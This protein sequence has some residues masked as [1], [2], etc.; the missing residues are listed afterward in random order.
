MEQ[1][2]RDVKLALGALGVVYG[3]LGTSPLYALK[4][5]LDWGGGATPQAALGM[6]S[7]I[8]WTLVLVISVKYVALVMRADSEGE[9]GI[10]VL[11]SQLGLK[12]RSRPLIVAFGILGAAL[13]YGDGAITPAISVLSALE[14]LKEPFPA[15]QP[16]ILPMT[17]AILGGLFIL[18]RRG[19]ATIGRVFGPIMLCWFLVIGLLGLRQILIHPEVFQAFDP[20]VG[21]RY[22][23]GHG[24][25]GIPVLGAV[26]LSAT[27]AEALY[28]DMGHFGAKPIRLGWYGLVLPALLLSYAGQ[29][30]L[31]ASGGLHDGENPFF[32][33]GPEALRL[34]LVLLATAATIIA[35]QSIISGAF[36]MTRQAIQ[37]GL[38]P[39]MTIVQTSEEG[40]GQI[41]V[42]FVNW[43]LMALTIGL[44]IGF[45]SSDNLAAAFGIAV[46]MTMLLTTILMAV[47]MRE[48]WKWRWLSVAALAGTLG[49]IDL[50]FVTANLTKVAEGGWVPLVVGGTI[51]FLM[52]SWHYGRMAM[53][54]ALKTESMSV[55]HFVSD[56]LPRYS[57][58]P[59][60]AVYLTRR[61]GVAPLALLNTLK[62]CKAVHQ[63]LIIVHVDVQHV[64]RI[65]RD[66]RATVRSLGQ[67]VWIVDMHYG[68]MEHPKLPRALARCDFGHM[69]LM[70]EDTTFVVSKESIVFAS[71]SLL[72]GL[73]RRLFEV[74]HRNAADACAY[75]RIPP[76]RTLEL[77]Q[78]LQM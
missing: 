76:E 47:L 67:G 48:V 5:A 46:A 22:L 70:P 45:K 75:F 56:V 64:P 53:L 26:F 38:L 7:L 12:K 23:A 16:V 31:V 40:Y 9:G 49:V 63:R 24:L 59:G 33:L 44:T 32:L 17:V 36:S 52:S 61:Q 69:P 74:M 71:S 42:G 20:S 11:M 2:G 14:G 55:G 27:G 43:A 66:Q 25:A 10:L 39:R 13:L 54:N 57:R 21:I 30:A 37:L 51:F 19:T 77:G 68:F 50:S 18:Q 29:A 15:V 34:P 35:S 41:Y 28:A 62:H 65:P 8:V 6:L 3:D 78:R 73:S 4:T 72:T 1:S 60:T 58:V